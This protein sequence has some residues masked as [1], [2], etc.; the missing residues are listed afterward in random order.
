MTDTTHIHIQ[1]RY[2]AFSLFL[3][4]GTLMTL[5]AGTCLTTMFYAFRAMDNWQVF[6]LAALASTGATGVLLLIARTWSFDASRLLSKP[7]IML[8]ATI[9]SALFA[10]PI[11]AGTTLPETAIAILLAISGITMTLGY[12]LQMFLWGNTFSALT[13]RN[14]IAHI[15]ISAS[16]AAV[17]ALLIINFSSAFSIASTLT[18]SPLLA[19][20]LMPQASPSKQNIQNEVQEETKSD[21]QDNL[22]LTHTALRTSWPVFTGASLCMGALLSMWRSAPEDTASFSPSAI[23]QGTLLGFILC[24]LA[25][26]AFALIYPH[27]ERM[28]NIFS[29]L[30]PV[31]A[32]LPLLLCIFTID[33]GRLA[34]F[35]VGVCAGMGFAFFMTIPLSLL[36]KEGSADG[37]DYFSWNVFLIALAAAGFLGAAL[38]IMGSNEQD[39]VIFIV[40]FVA[41]LVIVAAVP[42]STHKEGVSSTGPDS[43]QERCANIVE[44][45]RLTS[46][47]A[48]VLSYLAN[49]RSATYTAKELY[50]SVETV[51]VHVKHIYEKLGV[52]SRDEL[53]DLIQNK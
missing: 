43:L 15:G 13:L 17:I 1:V 12:I 38:A 36:Y 46:R 50:V 20:L 31:F 29:W 19:T 28:R 37:K 3:L 24:A 10:V 33:P 26:A 45:Y 22:P 7:L 11:V 47:E 44:C 16:I 18:L 49:G 2:L 21:K 34:G 42:R 53:L 51:K 40:L 4:S 8:I 25:L 41:Y 23:T 27:N 35:I 9:G 48:D 52:H 39:S 32:A 30:S 14:I 5:S 6:L